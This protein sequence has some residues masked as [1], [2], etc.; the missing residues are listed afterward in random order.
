MDR[1]APLLSS[2]DDATI[3]SPDV[4]FNIG[5]GFLNAN[6]PE[7]AI[8]YFTKAIGKDPAYADGYF[9]RGL[10]ALQLGRM[11]EAKTDL[12]K[13]VELTPGASEQECRTDCE[14]KCKTAGNTT[15]CSSSCVSGCGASMGALARKALSQI[16]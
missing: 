13:V 3:A 7:D 10:A 12:Q 15:Q 11:A 8:T 9:R 16:N 1:A 6:K 14:T 4:Y 2:L 5:V